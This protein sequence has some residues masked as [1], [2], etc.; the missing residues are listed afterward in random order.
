[1]K[2][3]KRYLAVIVAVAMLVTAMVPAFAAETSLPA[4]SQICADLGMIVG[5]GSG[6]T[7]DYLATTPT[8]IQGAVMFLRLKGLEADAKAYTGTDNFADAAQADW[9][10]PIMAYLKANPTLGWVGVG[11]NTFD[12]NAELTAQGYYKIMLEAL[13]Y[14]QGTDF[15]WDD[16]IGFAKALGMTNATSAVSFTISDLAKAT[17]EALKLPVKGESKLLVATLVEA[18]KLTAEQAYAA[19]LM[20]KL[21]IV[22]VI[23]PEDVNATVGDETVALP[24]TVKVKLEDG[25]E[26]DV[27]VTWGTVDT[28]TA[29]TKV[30]EGTIE[31]TDLKASVNVIVASDV[32]EVSSVTA[33][34]LKEIEV[35]FS[36]AVDKTSA[37]NKDAY[38]VIKGIGAQAIDMATL[39]ADGNTVVLTMNGTLTSQ[40]SDYKL[41][42]DKIKSAD[43]AA[44]V[45]QKDIVFKPID[46][47]LP[48]V[49]D[50]VALGN[51]A[52]KVTFA[53]PVQMTSTVAA[54]FKIDG[55]VV[56]GLY[57]LTGR[58][59]T[60]TLFN[61]LADG[62]HNI[63]INN[64]IK[65]Y[66]NYE[67]VEVTTPFTVTADAAAPS[68]AEIKDVTL[69]GATVVFSEDVKKAEAETAANYYWKEGSTVKAAAT[70]KMIDSKTVKITFTGTNRLPG[71][72]TDLYVKNV[73]D[74]SGNKIAADSKLAVTATLDKVSPEVLTYKFDN[75]TRTMTLTFSKVVLLSSFKASNVIVKDKDA[76][77]VSN[78]Y[79]AALSADGKT[80]TIT[81]TSKL[82]TAGTYSFEFTGMKD[83]TLL[84]NAMMP[85]T[86]SL[87]VKN[88]AAPIATGIVGT[89]TTYVISFDKEMDVSSSYSILNPANYYV[90]YTTTDTPARTISGLLP[91]ATNL[92]PTNGNKGVIITFP[93]G[94]AGISKMT[95]QGVKD[96]DGNFLA[97]YAKE[98]TSIN[99]TV[100]ITKA[101]ATTKTKIVLT[102]EQPMGAVNKDNFLV[103]AVTPNG[104]ANAIVVSA[105]AVDPA[106]STK[107]NL[108]LATAMSAAATNTNALEVYTNTAGALAN[109]TVGV[110]GAS[111]K[112]YANDGGVVIADKITPTVRNDGA[113]PAKITVETLAGGASDASHGLEVESGSAVV[114]KI[115]VNFGETIKAVNTTVYDENFK[116]YR[117]DGTPLVYGLDYT[118]VITG[119]NE[120]ATLTFDRTGAKLIDYN[121]KLQIVFDNTNGNIIDA[122]AAKNKANGFDTNVDVS[123]TG[124]GFIKFAASPLITAVKMTTDASNNNAYGDVGD[125]M[126]I[127]FIEN[128]VLALGDTTADANGYYDMTATE[129]AA[130]T[131]AAAD[132]GA[133]MK[134]KVDANKVTIEVTTLIT[135]TPIDV[136]DAVIGVG[137]GYVK[138]IAG[139][140]QI[141][142]V[143]V[144]LTK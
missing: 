54:T 95:V 107:I 135:A 60:L 142:A 82:S 130:I 62:E 50:A 129:F 35:V 63:T 15:E 21:D 118:V 5:D 84:E 125:I 127:T 71:Y 20:E 140:S 134:A 94:V 131:G 43:G 115:F 28:T 88:T 98:F 49:V 80:L 70:A 141:A 38:S 139:N 116:V 77:V 109:T 8:R 92:S 2:G 99:G 132:A 103:D 72:T 66:N 126:E 31:G 78:G 87:E 53:E 44:T 104:T 25:S 11:N 138:D 113:S 40:A 6:V 4:D 137:N 69:E 24:E 101:E 67:I 121:G 12:P 128:V 65:D 33:T 120:T 123:D 42:V 144:N 102:M 100:A 26:K 75:D 85:F 76:K 13:G 68:I 74:F 106:D 29:G 9:A 16:V 41:S 47:T 91:E 105:A 81:F 117:E 64:K 48:T 39:Q 122:S 73:V 136:G 45:S 36:M 58:S 110:T 34:N 18:G 111:I 133:A 96:V 124:I 37:E 17:V 30:V 89:G 51:K 79:T 93:N 52:V 7:S 14:K 108:T 22:E 56:S 10:K 114:N 83:N 46:T 143:G 3:L 86:A 1:M 112:S 57:E 90:T 27:A 32:L 19:G 59:V 119:S 61:S 55:V 97:G 23:N